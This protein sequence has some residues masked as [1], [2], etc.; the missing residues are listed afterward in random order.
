MF[1]I[2]QAFDPNSSSREIQQTFFQQLASCYSFP[3]LFGSCSH[4]VSG[5]SYETHDEVQYLVSWSRRTQRHEHDGRRSTAQ[6]SREGEWKQTESPRGSRAIR[7]SSSDSLSL[8]ILPLCG[9]RPYKDMTRGH[10]AWMKVILD[11][12]FIMTSRVLVEQIGS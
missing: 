9:H 3:F 10:A 1:Q 8:L 4:R 11:E 12:S 5:F 2:H 6:E 7:T